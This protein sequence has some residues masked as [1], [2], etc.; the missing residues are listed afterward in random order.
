[1]PP[2][3]LPPDD[4]HLALARLLDQVDW[5]PV[6]HDTPAVAS[7]GPY[8]THEGVLSTPLGDIPCYQLSSGERVFDAEAVARVFGID[9]DEDLDDDGEA[10]D[11]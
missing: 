11:L 4:F 1:M 3:S 5:R 9:L 7:A 6:P 2:E 10:E 8:A